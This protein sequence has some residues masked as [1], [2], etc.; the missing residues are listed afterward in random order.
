MVGHYLKPSDL[1]SPGS[2]WHLNAGWSFLE[3]SVAPVSHSGRRICFFPNRAP[4]IVS[5]SVSGAG[6]DRSTQN[7]SLADYP[8]AQPTPTTTPNQ[9]HSSQ[10][11]A[12]AIKPFPPHPTT[13]TPNQSHSSQPVQRSGETRILS[14]RN[15][16][17]LLRFETIVSFELLQNRYPKY[18]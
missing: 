10:P 8:P 15:W 11:V 16:S 18:S 1:Q 14:A 2:A 13:T 4:S 7:N 17:R 12:C 9:S 5:L 3:P 6:A